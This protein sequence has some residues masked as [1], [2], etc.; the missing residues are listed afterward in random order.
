MLT[1]LVSVLPTPADGYFAQGRTQRRSR[2]T[3]RAR[4]PPLLRG[5]RGPDGGP[6]EQI[7]Y[8]FFVVKENRSYDQIFGGILHGGE[9]RT[10]SYPQVLANTDPSYPSD[11]QVGCSGAPANAPQRPELLLRLGAGRRTAAG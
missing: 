4:G 8:V 7:R 9:E 6:S 10:D 3:G 2:A 1:G 5:R 11:L